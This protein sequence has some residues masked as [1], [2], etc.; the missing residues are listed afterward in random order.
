M[1][2]TLEYMK[3][4]PY[5]RSYIHN[6]MT[7][8][9]TYIFDEKYI[10]PLS[11][12]E[13]VHC[14]SSLIEKMPGDYD[15]KFSGL[16]LY[17]LYMMTHPGKK[18]SFMGNEFGQFIEW[19]ENKQL[20]WFLLKYPK[21]KM[22]QYFIKK[23]NHFYLNNSILYEIDNNWDGFEW[24]NAD[25]CNNNV[26]VY[27]RKNY[28]GK[29]LYVILNFSGVSLIDYKINHHEL[30]GIYKIIFNTNDSVYGGDGE[31]QVKECT[32]KKGILNIDIPKMIG[33]VLSKKYH[34]I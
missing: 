9:S 24:I 31:L 7:F 30:N 33:L 32:A 12:D 1:N 18:L 13:V 26:Y 34:N 20:D 16:R 25:D 2:D 4:D 22:F 8:T 14:K 10:L 15:L 11:H 19:D 3:T 27:T 29:L 5:F 23:L 17:Y 28:Q 6:K 21:H